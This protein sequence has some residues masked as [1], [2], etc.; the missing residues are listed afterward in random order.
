M[1]LPG[2]TAD[3][4]C[5]PSRRAYRSYAWLGSSITA[6]TPQWSDGPCFDWE[7]L[8]YCE[9][10]TPWDAANCYEACRIPCNPYAP[11]EMLPPG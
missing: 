2:F 4:A 6:V 9:E 7:C 3:A 1:G 8:R 11:P 10:R 5:Y